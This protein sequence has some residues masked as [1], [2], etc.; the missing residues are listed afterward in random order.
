[1]SKAPKKKTFEV[2]Y[3]VG[4]LKSAFVK[5]NS[6][7]EA[8]ELAAGLTPDKLDRLPGSIIENEET[9]IMGVFES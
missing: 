6:L 5:A 4:T 1:M 2:H 8:V 7:T 9:T 3:R